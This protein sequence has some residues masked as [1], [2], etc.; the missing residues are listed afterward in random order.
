MLVVERAE[1]VAC[2]LMVNLRCSTA[3]D[4]ERNTEVFERLLDKV[5]IAVYHLLN[6]DAFLAC[7]DCHGHTVLVATADEHHFLL[8][9]AQIAHIDVG[10][11]I[12]ASQVADVYSTVGVWQSRSHS[13]AFELVL[14]H[15][16]MCFLISSAKLLKIEAIHDFVDN[17]IFQACLFLL[18]RC[19]LTYSKLLKIEIIRQF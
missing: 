14:F 5:V 9:Q 6:R 16:I 19:S 7:A 11:H 13:G 10:R 4:V 18:L 1:E 3:I 15:Y 12:H 2:E 17:K 8:L